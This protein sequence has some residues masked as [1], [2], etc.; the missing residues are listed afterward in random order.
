MDR[1]SADLL[2]AVLTYMAKKSAYK[3]AFVS[4]LPRAGMEGTVSSLLRNTPLAGRLRIKSGSN[5]LVTAYAGYLLDEMDKPSEVVIA[6]INHPGILR[7]QV[8]RD[9]EL[10]LLKH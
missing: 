3:E 5:Q 1:V 4:A 10:F 8:K 2:A 9:V 6:L 7:S